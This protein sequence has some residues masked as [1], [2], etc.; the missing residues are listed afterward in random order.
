MIKAR[1]IAAT[2]G[3]A[4]MF[5]LLLSL[6][7]SAAAAGWMVNGGNLSGTSAVAT[8]ASVDKALEVTTSN[9]V[10]VCS[11]KT[12]NGVNPTINGG[13]GTSEAGS[14]EFTECKVS[15]KKP[16]C[17]L[18][19]NA[20]TTL[21]VS[22]DLALEGTLAIKGVILSTNTS[23]ILATVDFVGTECG[24]KGVSVVNGQQ[25][26]SMSEGQDEGKL[27][28]IE[29]VEE[30]SNLKVGAGVVHVSGASLLS[31]ASNEAFSFL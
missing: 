28:L 11:G 30:G 4:L 19:Q 25:G 26:F 14:L 1:R 5:G 8:T 27:Q 10:V 17:E 22:I 20:I 15:G 31:L 6:P 24:I 18:S 2:F 16:A 3:C 29:A 9:V 13:N 21:P 12:Y 23:K 7:S